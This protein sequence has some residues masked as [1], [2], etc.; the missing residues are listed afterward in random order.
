MP[1][2]L[3]AERV[4]RLRREKN[5]TIDDLASVTGLSYAAISR[6]ERS[7]PEKMSRKITIRTLMALA[8]A[9]GTSM[10]YLVGWTTIRAPVPPRLPQ[11]PPQDDPSAIFGS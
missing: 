5:W 8:L 4:R 3:L 6:L 1:P 7:T 9:L 2:I 11:T 10:E